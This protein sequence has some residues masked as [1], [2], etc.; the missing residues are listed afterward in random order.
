[1]QVASQ[2][3]VFQLCH[4]LMMTP[5]GNELYILEIEQLGFSIGGCVVCTTSWSPVAMLVQGVG[6]VR[7]CG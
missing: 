2:P 7:G 6:R 3:F 5:D 4:E 1:M